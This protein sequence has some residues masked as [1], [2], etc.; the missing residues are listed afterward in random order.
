MKRGLKILLFPVAGALIFLLLFLASSGGPRRDLEKTRNTLRQQGYKTDL[1]DFDFSVPP[2]VSKRTTVLSSGTMLRYGSPVERL[3]FMAPVG[4]ND[5]LVLWELPE[6]PSREGEDGWSALREALDGKRASLDA[7]ANAVL[8]GPLKFEL[9]ER[10]GG[11]MPLPHLA[12][13]RNLS[14]CFAECA[15]L[16]LHDRQTTHAERVNDLAFHDQKAD[17]WTNLLALTR[18]VTAWEVEPSEVSHMLRCSSADFAYKATWQVLQANCWTD[19]QL[20]GLQREWENVDYFKGLPETEAFAR[21]SAAA[22]FEFQRNQPLRTRLPLSELIHSPGAAWSNLRYAWDES[23]YR[24]RGSYED[25][26]AMMLECCERE[27]QMREAIQSPTWLQMRQLPAATNLPNAGA[28]SPTGLARRRTNQ[29]AAMLRIATIATARRVGVANNPLNRAAEAEAHRRVLITAIAL[30]RF[31][32]RHGHYPQK[33]AELSPELLSKPL[34]DFID[35]Q[36]LHYQLTKD[37]EFLLYSLSLDCIDHGGQFT[38]PA[39]RQPAI[40]S[41]PV[42]RLGLESGATL[43]MYSRAGFQQQSDILWPR[44]APFSEVK[45]ILDEERHQEELRQA[46]LEAQIADEQ[47]AA[48]ARRQEKVRELLE[49]I[50]ERTNSPASFNPAPDPVYQGKPLSRWLRNTNALGT[51]EATMDQ[52]LTLKQNI[53]GDEPANAT[54]ELPLNFDAVTNLGRLALLVDG[55]IDADSDDSFAFGGEQ[56]CR[57]ATNGNCLLTWNTVYDAPGQHVIQAAFVITREVPRRARSDEDPQAPIHT[58]GPMMPCY[59]S[60]LCQFS[61]LY[62]HFQPG[63]ATIYAKLAESNGIYSIEL[64]SP[65]G[66]HLRTFNGST[67]N[68]IIKVHWDMTDEHGVKYTNESFED[69][70]DIKLPDS[71]RRQVIK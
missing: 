69:T 4:T 64:K 7:V 62:S 39:F 15:I 54:F 37:G 43:A 29:R 23:R 71:G 66:E 36:P 38:P 63:S 44:P 11:P 35:G 9:Q 49:Q 30:E 27:K 56:N 26:Q 51:N 21:A 14:Q 46:A 61:Q 65:S 20:A 42:R 19:D 3:D 34:P 8:S 67:S 57:R 45:T 12:A 50:R 33:L 6:L 32:L 16:E 17:I 18:L 68:G 70:F 55:Q 28:F 31:H 41:M 2:E 60:N 58:V 59:S 52:L 53:T 25:E 47:D 22:A 40:S 24:R 13:I 10:A 5:A 1:A 48:E